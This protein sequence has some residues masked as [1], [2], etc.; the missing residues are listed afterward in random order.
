MDKKE[1]LSHHQFI[2]ERTIDEA[3]Y[4]AINHA[5]IRETARHFQIGRSAVHKDMNDRLKDIDEN[6]YNKVHAVIKINKDQ[7]YY[8]GGEAM[9]IK[10]KKRRQEKNEGKMK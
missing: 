9:R 2:Q 7:R 5:T 8:R 3:M 10:C 1:S 6:L 4:I